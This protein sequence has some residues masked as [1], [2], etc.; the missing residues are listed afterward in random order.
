VVQALLKPTVYTSSASFFPERSS[1]GLSGA[2][3][4]AQQFGINL[5]SSGNGRIPQFYQDLIFSSELLREIV[6]QHFSVKSDS[7]EVE[8][9]D[10]VTHFGRPT[11]DVGI[12]R[13]IEDLGKAINVS[14]S[15]DTWIVR[16][17]VKTSDPE[18][19]EQVVAAILEGINNFDRGIR[20]SQ[21]GAERRFVEGRL[22]QVQD[23]FGEAEDSLKHFLVNNR[24]FSNSPE[25]Q[26]EHDRLQRTVQMRQQ[27]L[28]SLTQ[29]FESAR[30]EEVRSTPQI[31]ML[32]YPRVPALRDA[33]GRIRMVIVGG[34]IGLVMGGLIAFLNHYRLKALEKR[35]PELD[36]LSLLWST[37]LRG[38]TRFG[39]TRPQ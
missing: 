27:V 36:E 15:V 30:I 20:Q 38:L 12:Q 7:G 29:S 4:L 21:A 1:S 23:E 24:A 35:N 26:F 32:E 17:S 34:I 25:L 22:A 13:A 18:L 28:T 11:A 10:L 2:T 9:I 33:K 14:Y 39:R 5:P 19:S 6:T 3:A 8:Q 37:T 16:F 31:T